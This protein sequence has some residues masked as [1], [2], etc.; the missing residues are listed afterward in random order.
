[1]YRWQP[2]HSTY[3]VRAF[4]E[5]EIQYPR[6]IT[7]HA[8]C[9]LVT[10]ARI[11]QLRSADTRFGPSSVLRPHQHSIGHMGDGFYR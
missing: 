4:C 7:S 2:V 6:T 11:N 9:Q 3:V 8:V 5:H 10:D 1:M